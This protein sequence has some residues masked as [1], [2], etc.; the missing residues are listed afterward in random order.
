M[1]L[2]L[3][4]RSG[5]TAPTTSAFAAWLE[6]PGYASLTLVPDGMSD[7]I[8]LPGLAADVLTTGGSSGLPPLLV[9]QSLGG[10][11]TMSFDVQLSG[12]SPADLSAQRDA[13]DAY[14][15][16]PCRLYWRSTNAARASWLDVLAAQPVRPGLTAHSD[17][18]YWTNATLTLTCSPWLASDRVW[19]LQGHALSTPGSVA[20]SAA[21]GYPAP[22]SISA[23]STG[24]ALRGLYLALGKTGQ[25]YRRTAAS[26]AWEAATATSDPAQVCDT[27]AVYST[28]GLID[29][30]GLEEGPYLLLLR[31]KVAQGTRALLS[32]V[33]SPTPV[34]VGDTSWELVP[35]A[36]VRL[37]PRQTSFML[38]TSIVNGPGPLYV[39]YSYWL[40]LQYG[41]VW[42]R[43][44][45]VQ[46]QWCYQLDREGDS[47]WVNSLPDDGNVTGATPRLAGTGMSLYA[48]AEALA[49]DTSAN[50]LEITLGLTP[51]YAWLR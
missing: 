43:S 36:M 38:W 27:Y 34:Y 14:L 33:I 18:A 6:K 5:G 40:P 51:R 48:V 26:I 16:E 42:Y 37:G 4:P 28:Q 19:P 2:P 23:R 15:R 1:P 10:A 50:P 9:R 46:A 44:Q 7:E 47:S 11:G 21:S 13:L 30:S 3:L 32:N 25:V 31:C 20:L 39:D 24:A 29:A 45:N 22:L 35:A 8:A 17:L 41:A 12:A 49:G